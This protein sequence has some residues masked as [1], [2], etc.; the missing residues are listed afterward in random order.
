MI[1]DPESI[2]IDDLLVTKQLLPEEL[3]HIA[4]I[5]METKKRIELIYVT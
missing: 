2:K 5:V 4:I 1:S 3:C